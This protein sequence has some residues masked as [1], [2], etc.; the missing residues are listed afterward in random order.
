MKNDNTFDKR[1]ITTTLKPL[2]DSLNKDHQEE[3]A[4]KITEI[5]ETCV[6]LRKFSEI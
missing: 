5:I 3:M 1:K 6:P 4:K 2:I